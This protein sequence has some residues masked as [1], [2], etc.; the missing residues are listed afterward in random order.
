MATR[1]KIVLIGDICEDIYIKCNATRL[2]PEVPVPCVT[3]IEKVLIDGM[4]A[5]VYANLVGLGFNEKNI[6]FRFPSSSITKTRYVDK[7]TGHVFLRVDEGEPIKKDLAFNKALLDDLPWDEIQAVI[8]SDYCKGYLNERS[9]WD[10]IRTANNNG[11]L[12]FVDTKLPLGEWSKGVDY[13]KINKKEYDTLIAKGIS[14]PAKWCK[15]LIVTLGAEG[16][17]WVNRNIV[18][19]VKK[20]NVADVCGCGDVYHAAF[21]L[22]FLQVRSEV[23]AMK[24][25]NAA[26][27]VAVAKQGVVVVKKEEV[28]L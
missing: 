16:S 19:P 7:T 9:L 14:Q 22:N 27:A 20:V 12:T 24:Y 25:A 17:W 6:I 26:A 11:V 3:P 21:A 10:I 13:I 2:A 5:N 28:V 15:N 4:A 8:I 23:S 1:N 18:E